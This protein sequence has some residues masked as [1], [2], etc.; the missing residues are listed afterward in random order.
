MR[1]PSWLQHPIWVALLCALVAIGVDGM[2][3]NTSF[4]SNWTGLFCAG[5]RYHRPLEWQGKQYVMPNSRG[6]DG[7]FYDLIAHDPFFRRGYDRF[8]DAPRLRY[9]R[10]LIPGLAWLLAGGQPGY[11]DAA[12]FAVSWAMIA[13]GAFCL[14]ELAVG[15]GRPALWGLLFL[16]AP[17]TLATIE[18]MTVDVALTALAL[19]AML[20][21]RAE[22]WR[23]LWL[24]LAAAALSKETGALVVLAVVVWLYRRAQLRL[25]VL[26]V[27][28]LLPALLWDAF[29]QLH[30]HGD[31]TSS[32]F[33]F[34]AAF[35][36]S[37]TAPLNPGVIDFVLRVASVV[38]VLAL[39]AIAV[40]CVGLAVRD[41]FRDLGYLIC[42]FFAVL[43]LLFQNSS[44]WEEP[45]GYTRIYSP[46]LVCLIAATWHRGFRQTLIGFAAVALPLCLQLGVHIVGPIL[47]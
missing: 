32:D 1:T 21:A 37:L 31:F 33:H 36:A 27:S 25:A 35:F 42:F 41:G 29:V 12:Y 2:L 44:I 28:S 3:V 22:R 43:L 9:R 5:D 34:G 26:E 7:Q 18:R 47:R 39:L 45:N 13:L 11:I 38:A 46:L 20:A 15:A 16:L 19:A 14:A 23:W 4:E 17:A 24:V 6:Y 8:V 30:T 40:R 10:I